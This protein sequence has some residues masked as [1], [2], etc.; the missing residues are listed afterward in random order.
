MSHKC[1][2]EDGWCVQCADEYVRN[3]VENEPM[4]EAG[5]KLIEDMERQCAE[6]KQRLEDQRAAHAKSRAFWEP[7]RIVGVGVAIAAFA[8]VFTVV[9]HGESAWWLFA[10]I[11]GGFVVGAAIGWFIEGLAYSEYW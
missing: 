3:Y 1:D 2:N 5:K 11:P 7:I 8:S 10:T 9:L 6:S 4:S